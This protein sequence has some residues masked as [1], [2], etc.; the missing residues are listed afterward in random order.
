MSS[1]DIRG[2]NLGSL[3]PP[4]GVHKHCLQPCSDSLSEGVQRP[5]ASTSAMLIWMTSSTWR[6]RRRFEIVAIVPRRPVPF[7]L[8]HNL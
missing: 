8:L 5:G 6:S 2:M 7:F 1:G 4:L 3:P